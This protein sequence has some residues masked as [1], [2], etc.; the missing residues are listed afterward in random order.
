MRLQ[1]TVRIAM[2]TIIN[3]LRAFIG[4]LFSGCY[5]RELTGK[6]RDTALSLFDQL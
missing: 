4:W 6:E 3:R 1:V 2:Q 5:A